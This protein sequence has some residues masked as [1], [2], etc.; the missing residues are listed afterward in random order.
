M[1]HFPSGRAC[2][3]LGELEPWGRGGWTVP[4]STLGSPVRGT[5]PSPRPPEHLNQCGLPPQAGDSNQWLCSAGFYARTP[6]ARSLQA[7]S[8]CQSPGQGKTLVEC[9]NLGPGTEGS[10]DRPWAALAAPAHTG[11]ARQSR[12]P[13]LR[14]LTGSSR[15]DLGHR[16]RLR[17]Q[18][19]LMSRWLWFSFCNFPPGS[20]YVLDRHGS[21]RSLIPLA[22]TGGAPQIREEMA[23]LAQHGGQSAGSEPSGSHQ[24]AQGHAWF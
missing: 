4:L 24:E 22:G 19:F 23:R 15:I 5:S 10:S 21:P 9:R 12:R 6:E 20:I 11:V 16:P 18:C 7:A 13:L 8:V 2:F 14:S 3:R 17:N 1:I